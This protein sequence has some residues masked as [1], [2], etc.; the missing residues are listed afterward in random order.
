LILTKYPNAEFEVVRRRGKDVTVDVWGDPDQVDL[1]KLVAGPCT[2]ILV[3]SGVFIVVVPRS[4]TKT[5]SN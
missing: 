2:D 3:E 4:G 5:D 1:V